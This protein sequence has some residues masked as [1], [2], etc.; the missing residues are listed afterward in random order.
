MSRPRSNS[1]VR[2]APRDEYEPDAR[3]RPLYTRPE[4][5]SRES[6]VS[7][8]RS[9]SDSISDY[10]NHER[11]HS[12]M[13]RPTP[14]KKD[15]EWYHKKTLWSGLATVATVAAL[16]PSA[17][18]AKASVDAAHASGRAARAS[19]KSARQVTKSARAS[20]ISAMGSMISARAVT[21]ANI[22][23]GHQDEYGNALRKDSFGR[24]QRVQPRAAL[25][26]S[27]S[28]DN[29]GSSRRSW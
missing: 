5:V 16:L 29:Y 1:R 21:N 24:T 6:S 27:Y 28:R 14:S 19:E 17:V 9:R 10:R 13:P 8:T 15:K 23:Q 11:H 22:A 18:S 2:F 3:G 20:Q 7:S 25:V 4:P 26:D 12:G